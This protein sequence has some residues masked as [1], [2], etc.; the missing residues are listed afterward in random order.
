M[1]DLYSIILTKY[2]QHIVIHGA[3]QTPEKARLDAV[4]YHAIL[5]CQKPVSK[6]GSF[7]NNCQLSC[8]RVH[9]LRY[10]EGEHLPP[11]ATMQLWRM[12]KFI[13]VICA[14]KSRFGL[15]IKSPTTMTIKRHRISYEEDRIYWW[16]GG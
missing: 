6:G 15:T 16:F 5:G 7:T 4:R 1:A 9:N 3:K 8:P 13:A 11:A 12:T 2:T 10:L 14:N